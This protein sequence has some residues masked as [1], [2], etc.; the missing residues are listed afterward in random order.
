MRHLAQGH[1]ALCEL[2]QL[3]HRSAGIG[4]AGATPHLTP[5]SE[6]A[7]GLGE[8]N[9]VSTHPQPLAVPPGPDLCPA[10][11][12]QLHASLL[13]QTLFIPQNPAQAI[14]G[15]LRGASEPGFLTCKRC[16]GRCRCKEGDVLAHGQVCSRAERV[17]ACVSA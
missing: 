12:L 9:Q 11:G 3:S 10:G 7:P 13:P 16:A 17:C 6:R 14:T 1:T 2:S 8:E 5:T 4:V 15:V